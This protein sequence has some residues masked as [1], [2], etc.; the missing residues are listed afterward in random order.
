MEWISVSQVCVL[1]SQKLLF[2]LEVMQLGLQSC[3]KSTLVYCV[4]FSSAMFSDK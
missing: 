2:P 4:L 1:A 3:L